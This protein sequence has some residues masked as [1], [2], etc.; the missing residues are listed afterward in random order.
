VTTTTTP[1]GGTNTT[2]TTTTGTQCTG[3][4]QGLICTVNGLLGGGH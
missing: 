3:L 2:G 1:S 4:L